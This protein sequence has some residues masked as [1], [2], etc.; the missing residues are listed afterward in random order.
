MEKNEPKPKVIIKVNPVIQHAI[1]LIAMGLLLIWC[2]FILSPFITPLVWAAVLATT[3]YPLHRVLTRKLKN[4]SALSAGIISVGMLLLIIGPGIWLLAATAGE[5]KELVHSYRSNDLH[6]PPPNDKVAEWPLIGDKVH[7]LWMEAFISLSDT[8]ANHQEE[9]K[10]YIFKFFD[11]IKSSA[12]GLL[13]FSLSIAISGVMLAYAKEGSQ[14]LKSFFTK[15]AGKAGEDMAESAEVTVRNVVKGIL[16]VA[17]IQTI[18][19]GVGMVVV[20]IPFAGVWILICLILAIIQVGILPVSIGTIIYIWGSA[21]SLTATLFTIWMILAGLLDNFL[22]PILLGKGAPAPMAIVF[23]GAIGGFL[24]SGF[25]GLFT[26]AIILTLG[27]KLAVGWLYS[28]NVL[29]NS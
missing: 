23:M 14:M 26:G 13:L 19:A 12:T 28:E 15:L 27:Y 6:L 10:P 18:V 25:I 7:A 1:Q 11:L 17:L 20:G 16:G 21:D 9:I 5:F 24:F 8:M 29:I 4:K 22:K 2:F 3:F